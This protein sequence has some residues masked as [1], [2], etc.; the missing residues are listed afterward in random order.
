MSVPA[1]ADES[2]ARE[3]VTAAFPKLSFKQVGFVCYYVANGGAKK[4]A[5][6]AAGYAP[7]SAHVEAHRLLQNITVLQAIQHL[8]VVSFAA[9][10]PGAVRTVSTLSTGAK[11]EYVRLQAAESV[12][13]RMGMGRQQK[14]VHGGSVQVTYDFGT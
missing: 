8:S 13:D 11:S 1:V 14:V 2:D 9:A 3:V 10:L 12:L 5:A 7:A 4:A 6:I